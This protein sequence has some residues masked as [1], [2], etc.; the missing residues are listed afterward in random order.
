MLTLQQ[1]DLCAKKLERAEKLIG[2]L[3]G[4]K[5]RWTEA[6]A[7]LQLVYDNLTGDVL[8]SS[9][10]IAYLGAFTGSYRLEATQD[11]TAQCKSYNITCSNQF[12]LSQC[13]GDPIKIRAWNIAGL[14]TDDFS[15]DNGVIVDNSRRW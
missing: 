1:I 3:G 15:I 6:A 10:V 14:P 9:G 4:E 7:N 5:S 2:G 13:L 11:W 8:I 12:S